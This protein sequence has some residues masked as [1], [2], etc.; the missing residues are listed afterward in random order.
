MRISTLN[1]KLKLIPMT[2]VLTGVVAVEEA[3]EEGEVETDPEATE[4][5]KKSLK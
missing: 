5:G 2:P 1:P 4:T 3:E